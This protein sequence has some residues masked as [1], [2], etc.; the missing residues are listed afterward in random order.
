MLVYYTKRGTD[1]PIVY[2]CKFTWRNH[3]TLIL[4]MMRVYIF[5]L[6]ILMTSTLAKQFLS[7]HNENQKIVG[8]EDAEQG[9]FPYQ[10][11]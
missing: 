1:L 2:V 11:W 5:I 7:Y 8:G 6:A 10:V 3:L 9:Q 4:R